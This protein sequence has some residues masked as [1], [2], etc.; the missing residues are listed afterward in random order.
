M[1]LAIFYFFLINVVS[2]NHRRIKQEGKMNSE[3]LKICE[4]RK[5]RKILNT[6]NGD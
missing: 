3:I 5:P 4:L 2:L 1:F 6:F